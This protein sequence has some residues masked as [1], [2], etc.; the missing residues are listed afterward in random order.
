MLKNRAERRHPFSP[1]RRNHQI[2]VFQMMMNPMFIEGEK[3]AAFDESAD[4]EI[5]PDENR[6]VDYTC[7]YEECND[8]WWNYG[9]NWTDT[10]ELLNK[11]AP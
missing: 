1:N 10:W 8:P 4:K 2:T 7:G 3:Q 5:R 6:W 11:H 9:G